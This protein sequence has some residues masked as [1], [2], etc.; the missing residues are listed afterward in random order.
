MKRELRLAG[1][2]I[3]AAGTLGFTPGAR[4]PW[5]S[6]QMGAFVTDPISARPRTPAHPPRM[7][8]FP[9]GVLIH[10][11]L[12]NPG[13]ARAIRRFGVGWARSPVPVIVHVLAEGP[14]EAARAARRLEEVEGVSALEL[15]L[16]SEY[17][18][19]MVTEIVRATVGELP[20]WA[21]L[22]VD[23]G[24]ALAQAAMAAG[25]S[26]VSL[27]PPR[28]ALPGRGQEPLTGRLYGPAVYPLSLA[29]VRLLAGAGITVIGAGGVYRR[30]QAE[31]MRTAGAQAVQLDVVLWRGGWTWEPF[32]ASA[33]EEGI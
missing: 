7:A 16:L 32:P 2:W 13:L 9:G 3:N 23:H 14:D 8:R 28:G 11:G 33:G 18:P 21:R 30:D 20:I 10:T 22:P 5:D 17:S 6:A 27:G 19:E 4:L 29:R 31:A 12:P 15:G 1:P 24:L 26:A 25:A